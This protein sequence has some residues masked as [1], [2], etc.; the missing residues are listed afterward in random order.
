MD[1]AFQ[2]LLHTSGEIKIDTVELIDGVQLE[3]RFTDL[4]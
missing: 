4:V 3:Y 2:M 1:L